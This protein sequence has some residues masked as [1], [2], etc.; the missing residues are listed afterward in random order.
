MSRFP[1]R[2][3]LPA[4]LLAL[5]AA[6]CDG[7]GGGGTAVEPPPVALDTLQ[8]LLTDAEL[9]VEDPGAPAEN[10]AWADWVAGNHVP[11]RSLTSTSDYQDLQFLKPL[12]AG[13]RVVQLGESGH[14]V[15]Q[16]NQAKVRL[17][18][19]LH[20]EMDYD[21][22]AFESSLHDCWQVNRTIASRSAMQEMQDC[23]F[24]VWHTEEVRPL[25]SYIRGVA[26]TADPLI[27]AGVDVQ[28]V[29]RGEVGRARAGLLRGVLAVADS[30]FASRLEAMDAELTLRIEQYAS[31]YVPY[32]QAHGDSLVRAYARA[33]ELIRQNRAAIDAHFAADRQRPAV[34]LA[35]ARGMRVFVRQSLLAGAE[36]YS[37]RDAGM[38]DNVDLLLDELYPGKK[39]IIWGHNSHVAKT[40][41]SGVVNMGSLVH[42]R[43]GSEVY[44]LGL[45][46]YRGSAADNTRQ[47]Y[48]IPL[49]H[50]AGSLESVLYRARRRWTFVDFSTRTDGPGTSWI[51]QPIR[52]R[53]WGVNEETIS[54]RSFYDGVLLIHTVSPPEYL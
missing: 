53:S 52:A 26:S 40:P 37:T 34:A 48:P 11:L 30:G 47:V 24:Q 27:L 16:F 10:T 42:Q 38:A 15:R 19:F 39:V 54:P 1:L 2:P 18:R 6:A 45:F 32:M 50:P 49:P 12:L 46:M 14:G 22:I 31:V 35:A 3:V 41:G 8:R 44:T 7:G 29:S 5:F 9:A 17:I 4:I 51:F 28:P 25:V 33:E 43:R 23:L 13:R 21:V 20:E 36:R